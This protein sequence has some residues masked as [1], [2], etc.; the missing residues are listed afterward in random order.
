MF[1]DPDLF[2]Y[3]SLSV[4]PFKTIPT[5]FVWICFSGLVRTCYFFSPSLNPKP[6]PP[7]TPTPPPLSPCGSLQWRHAV[8][9]ESDPDSSFS[10][11]RSGWCPVVF[12]SA[13][14]W[15][16]AFWLRRSAAWTLASLRRPLTFLSFC[17]TQIQV[18]T[19]PE[20]NCSLAPSLMIPNHSRKNGKNLLLFWLL[21]ANIIK[22]GVQFEI[23][24]R[25][26]SK[27]SSSECA[28]QTLKG[29]STNANL[30]WATAQ[31]TWLDSPHT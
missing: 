1:Y 19:E 21:N 31:T 26:N 23:Q 20:E 2:R 18:H 14:A 30:I 5:R 10:P 24:W 6:P 15:Q 8:L 22:R 16:L 4:N 29:K 28:L 13:G 7:P 3:L 25:C 27:Q 12:P 11:N 9:I 17:K